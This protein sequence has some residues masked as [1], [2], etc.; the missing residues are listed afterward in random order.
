MDLVHR[1]TIRIPME[2]TTIRMI[3]EVRTMI[4]DPTVDT[5]VRLAA[6]D[7]AQAHRKSKVR[8]A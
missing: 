3:T 6:R 7:T 1:I 5:Q 4:M 8:F 2:V